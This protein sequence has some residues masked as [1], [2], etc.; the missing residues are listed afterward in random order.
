MRI[1]KEH[2]YGDVRSLEIGSNPLGKV[3]MTVRFYVVG[4]ILIDTGHSMMGKAA[5]AYL[6]DKN[7]H[8][9]LL[10]HHHEDHTG[11]AADIKKKFS[12]PVFGHP[13][14]A[15]KMAAPRRIMP[16]QILVWGAAKKLD[17]KGVETAMT[18]GSKTF[19]PIHC[20]GHS[21]DMTAWLDKETGA[22]FSGDLFIGER[23]KY[24]RSD[25]KIEL[26]IASL[27]KVLSLDFDILF[28]GHNPVLKNGGKRIQAKLNFL[29]DFFGKVAS[30]Y[31]KGMDIDAIMKTGSFPEHRLI[32]NLS[33]GNVSRRRMVLSC[34][35]A[36]D[37]ANES[38]RFGTK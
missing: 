20:P 15:K 11:N 2:R 7:I 16:Y 28:C 22:L 18:F 26:Q 36:I 12:I 1:V 37:M 24:F 29:E 17:V 38:K 4:N 31:D 21:P 6:E 25:E 5:L 14:T 8:A 3:L 35:R 33:M 9:A 34:L 10:T 23:I 30:F 27:K 19:V 32:R 13:I